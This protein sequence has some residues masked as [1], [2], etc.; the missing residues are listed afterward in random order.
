[1][2]GKHITASEIMDV[3]RWVLAA[4]ASLMASIP[5]LTYF[6]LILMVID[7][8]FG[9]TVAIKRRELSSSLAWKGATKKLGSLGIV[10]LAAF[11]DR[12]VNLLGLDLVQV[13][14]VFY[15]GPELLSIVR[16]AAILDI[17]VPPQLT[18]VMR[19]FQEQDKKNADVTISKNA[20]RNLQ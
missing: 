9:A 4:L 13:T 11:M 14:T 12:Y 6:L 10:V 20:G 1:M 17:P 2:N 16:N 5:E 3:G 18:G 7:T 19:Y 8:V 15:I